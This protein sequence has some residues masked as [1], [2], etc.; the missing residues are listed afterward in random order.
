M[1]GAVGFQRFTKRDWNAQRDRFNVLGERANG[2]ACS[3]EIGGYLT[4]P[5]ADESR[6]LG[7]TTS[8]AKPTNGAFWLGLKQ[9]AG[10][11]SKANHV[12]AEEAHA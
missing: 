10:G 1:F 3:G 9:C 8:N 12:L 11:L 5:N 6:K 7:R 4:A 2:R